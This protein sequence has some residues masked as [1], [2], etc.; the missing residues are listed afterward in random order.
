MLRPYDGIAF[1]TDRVCPQ[2]AWEGRPPILARGAGRGTMV[3]WMSDG[4]TVDDGS[5]GMWH[6]RRR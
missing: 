6:P 5:D 2:E 4:V 3:C 1:G